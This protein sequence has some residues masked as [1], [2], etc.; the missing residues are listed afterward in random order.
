MFIIDEILKISVF[1]DLLIFAIDNI[2][3]E[4]RMFPLRVRETVMRYV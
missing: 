1:I 3:N 4:G 2:L